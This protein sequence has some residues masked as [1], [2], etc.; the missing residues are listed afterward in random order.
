MYNYS[1]CICTINYLRC[2]CSFSQGVYVQLI[3]QDV[4]VQLLKVTLRVMRDDRDS[5]MSVLKTFIFDPLV[6]WSKPVKGGRSNPTET[7]E[8]RNEKAQTHVTHIEDR[9]RG[10]MKSK[11]KP[12]G[13]PL[14]VEGHVSHLIKEATEERNLCQMYVGWAAYM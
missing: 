9:L 1:R 8:I 14:S 3:T 6:E 5:L 11:N 2:I 13:L 7:G 12:P 10:V 4:Y